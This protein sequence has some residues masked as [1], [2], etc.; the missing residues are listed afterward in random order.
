MN[1]LFL[2]I[3]ITIIVLF[4][5]TLIITKNLFYKGFDLKNYSTYNE[6]NLFLNKKTFTTNVMHYIHNNTKED[7]VFLVFRPSDF[8]VYAKRNFYS[9]F[10]SEVF[11]IFKAK[12]KREMKSL[13][14]KKNIKY[15]Y[16]PYYLDSV[17]YNSK[18]IDFISD[19]NY[20]DFVYSDE[21]FRLYKVIEKN[22]YKK[23][24]TN[25]I[26]KMSYFNNFENYSLINEKNEFLKSKELNNPIKVN[27]TY[28][29]FYTGEGLFDEYH[30]SIFSI[31]NTNELNKLNTFIIGNGFFEIS[32]N[33]F[34]KNKILLKN[35][36]LANIIIKN[37]KKLSLIYKPSREARYFRYIIK[38]FD[39]N[40]AKIENLTSEKYL[41]L[42]NNNQILEKNIKTYPF[43]NNKYKVF[44]ENGILKIFDGKNEF[45]DIVDL[46]LGPFILSPANSEVSTL[47]KIEFEY[48][49]NIYF[50]FDSTLDNLRYDRVLVFDKINSI[51]NK[52]KKETIKLYA[53]SNWKK[54]SYIVDLNIINQIY[55]KF[56]LNNNDIYFRYNNSLKNNKELEIKSIKLFKLVDNNWILVDKHLNK[57]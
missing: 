9:Y 43:N 44:T 46:F 12:T 13:L 16:I 28:S 21:S 1:K 36:S 52:K 45:N 23:Y 19:L 50:N 2:I 54:Y 55:L 15:I 56:S 48:K 6:E 39:D 22:M 35:K 10:D 18:L 34:D 42:R 30:N 17:I 26:G 11:D 8:S 3:L 4:S 5:T 53:E 20:V 7:D 14:M 41:P 29:L 25:R 57:E 38:K 51:L 40:F 37:K 32:V 33:E 31:K 24:E 47:H 49:G 27:N